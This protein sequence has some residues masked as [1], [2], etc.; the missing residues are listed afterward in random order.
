MFEIIDYDNLKITIS[1]ISDWVNIN[2]LN[3]TTSVTY[4][5]RITKK[6]I[7]I[8][9]SVD[10][11]YQLMVDTFQKTNEKVTVDFE[12]VKRHSSVF[13]CDKDYLDM[14]FHL[15]QEDNSNIDFKIVFEQINEKD[16]CD[17]MFLHNIYKIDENLDVKNPEETIDS[18][19]KELQKLKIKYNDLFRIA[20]YV[21]V[22][23][24]GME[25]IKRKNGDYSFHEA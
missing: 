10:E 14:N 25:I 5:A 11:I 21:S 17:T 9:L 4:L 12:Y 16:M 18:L 22:E 23:E 6:T 3:K 7:K 19:K 1:N 24:T 13:K 20:K 8:D 2:V 15:V